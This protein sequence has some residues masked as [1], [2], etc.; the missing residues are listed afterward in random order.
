M[1]QNFTI[2]DLIFPYDLGIWKNLV[3]ALGYPYMW[4]IPFGKPKSNGYQ[5]QISQ[6]YK[7][8]DQLNLPGLLMVLD[9]K[10]LKLMCYNN[11]D[12]SVIGKRKTM[13]N[14]V[15]LEIIKN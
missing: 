13:K 12:I 8:D 3:N 4:L 9:K 1:P 10:K 14:Y 11:K 5:P 2:D 6:D 7:Q 15:V